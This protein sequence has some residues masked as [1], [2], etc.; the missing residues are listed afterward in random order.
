MLSKEQIEN[1]AGLADKATQGKWDA[2]PAGIVFFTVDGVERNI[3]STSCGA[4]M[5]C[6]ARF[7]AAANP[8]TVIELV[9]MLREAQKDAARLEWMFDN[10]DQALEI[11]GRYRESERPWIRTTIDAAMQRD[12]DGAHHTEGEK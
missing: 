6:N 2:A 8:K 12:C 11:L 7:I 1:L 10:A 3:A 9:A 4:N 5:H